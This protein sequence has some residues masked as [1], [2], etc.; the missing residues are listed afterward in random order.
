MRPFWL[1]YSR[2]H[3]FSADR[4]ESGVTEWSWTAAQ[5]KQKGNWCVVVPAREAQ[6]G[7]K[8]TGHWG[9]LF[10]WGTWIAFMRPILFIG[11]FLN[12]CVC[13]KSV[14]LRGSLSP[15][16][17]WAERTVNL[18]VKGCLLAPRSWAL[19]VC[20]SMY[21]GVCLVASL[22]YENTVLFSIS[23]VDHKRW[24]SRS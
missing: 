11:E 17:Q 21:V 7:G 24:V 9:I 13:L 18:G 22:I 23:S 14:I 6:L 16:E 15:D 12:V 20:E 2:K 19:C 5:R 10:V 1:Y 4:V 3:M 8:S